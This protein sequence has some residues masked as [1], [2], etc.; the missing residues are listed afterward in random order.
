MPLDRLRQIILTSGTELLEYAMEIETSPVLEP[1]AWYASAYQ[2]HHTA[3]LLILELFAFPMRKEADRIWKCLDYVFEVPTHLSRDQKARL[4]LTE[5]RD[6]MNAYRAIRK[7]RAPTGMLERLEQA[8]SEDSGSPHNPFPILGAARQP[9]DTSN[10]QFHGFANGEM[11]FAP[12][13]VSDSPEGSSE[14]GS[15]KN[16]GYFEPPN[17]KDDFMTD[18]DWVSSVQFVLGCFALNKTMLKL[19]QERMGQAV[20][21]GHQ[22]WRNKP[23]ALP[24][25]IVE[26]GQYLP[27][28]DTCMSHDYE[29]PW[30]LGI[31]SFVLTLGLP[32]IRSTLAGCKAQDITMC[33]VA[34][35]P[36]MSSTHAVADG[37]RCDIHLQVPHL[38]RVVVTRKRHTAA[39]PTAM[40]VLIT[41]P[42]CQNGAIHTARRKDTRQR[43][44]NL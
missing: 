9:T 8:Q 25:S 18:I 5:L 1:W 34:Q 20:P 28:K 33:Q 38:R 44:A 32:T 42:S 6:K 16:T 17:A 19:Y 23:S 22:H 27:D 26:H 31:D 36:R 29:S 35:T 40:T 15:S 3:L 39:I 21:T 10:Y 2:Q 7:I 11:L 43:H 37:A 14:A 41:N 12:P 4:I 13:S 24:L 30:P